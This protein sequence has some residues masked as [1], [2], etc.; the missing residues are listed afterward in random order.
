LAEFWAS[1]QRT[2][3]QLVLLRRRLGEARWAEVVGGIYDRLH[4]QLGAGEVA[5][6]GTAFL[7]VGTR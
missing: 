4:A 3:V 1:A 2:N 5:A 7:G 6:V